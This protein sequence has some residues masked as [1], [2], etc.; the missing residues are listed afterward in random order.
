MT[1]RETRVART[2]AAGKRILLALACLF[3][4]PILGIWAGVSMHNPQGNGPGGWQVA[5]GIAVPA[6][7][8]AAAAVVAR[9]GRAEAATWTIV[10]LAATGG[11]LLLLVWFIQ[12]H[13]QT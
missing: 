1:N 2:R 13:I 10:S 11:L 7:L 5:V 3:V 4:A 9:V 12:T 8:A 6:L